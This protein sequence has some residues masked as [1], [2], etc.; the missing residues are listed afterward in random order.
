MIELLAGQMLP[1]SDRGR[2]EWGCQ[3]QLTRF[4]PDPPTWP[5]L[6]YWRDKANALEAEANA[7]AREITALK[8]AMNDHHQATAFWRETAQRLEAQ[9]HTLH[10][11]LEAERRAL[12]AMQMELE[13][14][15]T[16][17]A[18]LSL[19]PKVAEVEA[20]ERA[21]TQAED[22]LLRRPPV[23]STRAALAKS[24]SA[25]HIVA[26]FPARALQVWR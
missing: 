3:R 23:D 14:A 6:A 18:E 21:L 17:I 20:Y 7:Q 19:R 24:D 25:K 5:D 22:E 8:L 16:L 4:E 9:A 26:P 12:Q 11:T 10:A 1:G 15:R 2:P 13:I